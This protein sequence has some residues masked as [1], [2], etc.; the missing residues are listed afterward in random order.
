MYAWTTK[1]TSNVVQHVFLCEF[2]KFIYPFDILIAK[3]RPGLGDGLG[4][5]WRID[6][7]AREASAEWAAPV[8]GW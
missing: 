6:P 2:N 3:A 8:L 7:G 5:G 1:I 4:L